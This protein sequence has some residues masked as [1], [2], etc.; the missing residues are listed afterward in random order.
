M[1]KFPK[2]IADFL[3]EMITIPFITYSAMAGAVRIKFG[4]DTNLTAADIA[5]FLG[6]AK[7]GAPYLHQLRRDRE[8]ADW[9]RRNQTLGSLDQIRDACVDQFGVSRI[10]SRSTVAAFLKSEGRKRRLEERDFFSDKP[11]VAEWLREEYKEHKTV[12]LRNLCR[13]KFGKELTPSYETLRRFLCR[14]Q[15]TSRVRRHGIWIDAELS[16][17]LI[18]NAPLLRGAD[19]HTEAVKHFGPDRVGNLSAVRH[20]LASQQNKNLTRYKSRKQV[21]EGLK[22]FRAKPSAPQIK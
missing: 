16:A 9:L 15:G 22:I 5:T 7:K 13:E 19:L 4:R 18:E 12:D 11:Q 14:L 6:T 3:L 21:E 10:P 8:L 1:E 2:N 17:W 20:F